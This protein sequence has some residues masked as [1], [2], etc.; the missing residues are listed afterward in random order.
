MRANRLAA[1]VEDD[2]P[3]AERLVTKSVERGS[4][5]GSATSRVGGSP[6]Y[7][8]SDNPTNESSSDSRAGRQVGDMGIA[9][10]A[11]IANI[12]NPLKPGCQAVNRE[13]AAGSAFGR[14]R[15]E[16]VSQ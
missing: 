5:P 3:P 8:A 15:Q 12:G 10:I 6:A 9:N 2:R 7:N 4:N 11:N 1:G 14:L 13:R 16:A